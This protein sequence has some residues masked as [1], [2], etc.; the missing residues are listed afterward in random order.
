MNK[1][2]FWNECK[3]IILAFAMWVAVFLLLAMIDEAVG[4]WLTNHEV[5]RILMQCVI[6]FSAVGVLMLLRAK[7]LSAVAVNVIVLILLWWAD[8]QGIAESQMLVMMVSLVP[9]LYRDQKRNSEKWEILAG[10]AIVELEKQRGRNDEYLRLL[11]EIMHFLEKN[12]IR[13]TDDN[14]LELYTAESVHSTLDGL[15]DK[16][17]EE[18]P[19]RME[20]SAIANNF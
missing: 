9:L 6:Q 14:G 20:G 7:T 13:V 1:R 16:Y 18:D 3:N 8:T 19:P 2:D 15:L 10:S 5:T 4:C 17:V 11:R 12:A